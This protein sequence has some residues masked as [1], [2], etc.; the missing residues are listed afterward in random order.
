MLD[1][2]KSRQV[3]AE[4]E[5]LIAAS[6]KKIAITN[7]LSAQALSNLLDERKTATSRAQIE[8][9]ATEYGIEMAVLDELSRH[10]TAPSVTAL[11]STK[12]EL[13]ESMLVRTHSLYSL[14]LPML[15]ALRGFQQ[16]SWVEAA[17]IVEVRRIE[18]Q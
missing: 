14:Y 3:A 16:A 5:E 9:I 15:T 8:S 11:E 18:G 4:E 1:I 2:L 17:P 12:E 7:R 13:E 6:Y 10:I